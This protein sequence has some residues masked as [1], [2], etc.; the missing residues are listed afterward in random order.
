[1]NK[2]N[3]EE[4]YIQH[5]LGMINAMIAGHCIG[6]TFSAKEYGTEYHYDI[7]EKLRQQIEKD[8]RK[9]Y[10]YAKKQGKLSAK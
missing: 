4:D 9:L 10:K 3:L 5:T 6:I 8:I 2:K 1:M 7:G